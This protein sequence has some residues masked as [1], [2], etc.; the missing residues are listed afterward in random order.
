MHHKSKHLKKDTEQHEGPAGTARR[1]LPVLLVAQ[2]MVILDITAVNIALPSVAGDL[3]LSGS[4]MSWAITSYS[5]VFGSLLLFGGRAADLLGKRRMF[6]TGLGIFT[7]SSLASALA[8]T[9]AT[10]FAGRAGQ[11]LGAALLSPAALA[12]IMS[13][14]QGKQRAKALAAWGAV[15]GAGVQAVVVVLGAQLGGQFMIAFL[16]GAG[17]FPAQHDPLPRGQGEVA[18]GADRF[19]VA[20]LDTPVDLGLNHWG[21]LDV[22]NVRLRVVVQDDSGVE[23]PG[24]VEQFL[25]LA[26]HGI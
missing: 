2:L 20:A 25:D 18:A 15:G 13:A 19:A 11:G 26:H 24:R 23:Y 7:A 21:G 12:I 8:G 16:L 22:P 6:M 3:Q 14:F 1:L 17:Q 5:L 9:S 4:S 10:L